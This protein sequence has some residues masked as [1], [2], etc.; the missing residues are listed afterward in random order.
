MTVTVVTYL[1]GISE[2]QNQWDY[3]LTAFEPDELIV[4]GDISNRPQSNVFKYARYIDSISLIMED[5][6]IFAPKNGRYVQGKESLVTF[7]HPENATYLFGNDKL[8]LDPSV[9]SDNDNLVYIP[10][11]SDH[12]LYSWCVYSVAIWDR[13]SKL[14]G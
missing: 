1:P 5:L 12:D 11:D 14:N 9:V 8:N 6:I 2:F 3:V 13:R 4:I 7:E 10:T